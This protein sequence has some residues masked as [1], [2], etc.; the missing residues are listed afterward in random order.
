MDSPASSAQCVADRVDCDA[1]GIRVRRG[2]FEVRLRGRSLGTFFSLEEARSARDVAVRASAA[3]ERA[4]NRT[5]PV[6]GV[7]KTDFNV[8]DK[9]LVPG[10]KLFAVRLRN[11]RGGYVYGGQYFTRA[12]AER[13]ATTLKQRLG[14]SA[15]RPSAATTPAVR[16]ASNPSR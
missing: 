6:V 3:S 14:E 9:A 16:R 15:P 13:A 1:K 5:R 11:K 10:K 7:H 4:E 8:G 2:S 12:E